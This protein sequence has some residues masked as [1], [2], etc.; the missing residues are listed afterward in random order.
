MSEA[1][2]EQAKEETENGSV[3]FHDMWEEDSSVSNTP[4]LC[5]SFNQDGSCLAV[6]TSSGFAIRNVHPHQVSVRRELQGGI[7]M[8]E[9]LF[10][11]NLMAL[12]GGGPSP[13]APSYRVLIWDDHVQK[14]IGELS[15]R[16]VVL[17]VKLRRDA[18]A[19]ALRDRVYVYHLAD[20]SLRDKIYTADNPHGLLSL[21]SSAG[22][23]I[24]DE[25][26]PNM[27]LACPS[28]TEGHVRVELYGLRKTVLLE[29]HESSLRNI[30]LTSD[31]TKLAT[32]ST[33]GTVIRVWDVSNQVCLH[34]FRRGVERVQMTCLAWSWDHE[35]LACTSD[36]GTAHVFRVD[37]RP[38]E[39]AS[40]SRRGGAEESTKQRSSPAR[41]AAPSSSLSQRVWNSVSRRKLATAAKGEEKSLAQI[42]GVPQPLACAFVPDRPHTLAVVGLD[43]DGNGVLLL[44]EF[45]AILDNH[46]ASNEATRVAYHIVAKSSRGESSTM[47]GRKK[48]WRPPPG[49]PVPAQTAEPEGKLYV[50][51]RLEVLE[52]GMNDIRFDEEEDGDFVSITTTAMTSAATPAKKDEPNAEK[53]D[54]AAESS[55]SPVATSTADPVSAS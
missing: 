18:I 20:L 54:N 19:V 32:A 33:K 37:V 14:A 49:V 34:E 26:H 21:S 5:C 45:S 23:T 31:G 15:F 6:G 55:A 41:S 3:P 11:C 51:E 36:K 22:A 25:T 42:R 24:H 43:A 10:R 2:Q 46:L 27:I 47:S 4:M 38:T 9:M 39:S 52:N 13:H 29:A 12:V 28:V 7:G 30:L 8:V 50:G 1:N 53:P 35:W 44:S 48:R 17:G 40:K 16:Q